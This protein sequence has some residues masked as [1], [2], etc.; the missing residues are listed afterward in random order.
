MGFDVTDSGFY[1]HNVTNSK[2]RKKKDIY[3][4]L[5]VLR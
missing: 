4:T 5:N 2:V 1:Y 3:K